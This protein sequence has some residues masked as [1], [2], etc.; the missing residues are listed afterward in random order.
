MKVGLSI[1]SLYQ[2]LRTGEM[3]PEDAVNWIADNGADHMEVVDLPL[4]RETPGA[5]DAL[6]CTAGE[7]GLPISAYSIFANILAGEHDDFEREMER[8]YS[9]IDT[10]KKMD[11][12]V[13][14]S[15]LAEW[16]RPP[17]QNVIEQFERDLPQMVD[18]CR[19]MAGYAARQGIIVT[20]ENH[21]TYINGGDRV[22]RLIT[23]VDVPNFRC[24]L[25]VGNSLCVDA[26]PFVTVKTLLPF[27]AT[28]HF[29][30]F[31]VRKAPFQP[32]EGKWLTTNFG[33]CLRGSIVGHGDVDVSG[34]AAYI[35]EQGYN[36]TV[37]IEFEGMEDCRAGSK[38][39]MDCV[40]TLLND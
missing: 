9:E 37:S 3:T 5:L 34:I 23:S 13:M 27:A 31:Y 17:E 18:G 38:L 35:R 19:R 6:L 12:P 2:A 10:A 4:F 39:G 32:D 15:D 7:R 22:R 20:V 11:A 21:G 28:L 26:D 16:G 1:Y 8:V 24:T 14:R 36:G 40:R 25:D 30:D 33:T 29:K